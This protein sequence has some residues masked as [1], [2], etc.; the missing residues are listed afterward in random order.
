MSKIAPFGAP[1]AEPTPEWYVMR[2]TYQRELVAQ[3]LL[4]GLGVKSFVPTMKVKRRK[5]GGSFYW[6]E[7][8]K[9]HNYIFVYAT[10]PE[11]QKIK[12][13]KITYLRYMMAKGDEGSPT[14][15]FVPSK[16]MEDFMAVCRSEGVRYLDTEIDL[17]KGDRV[18]ILGGPLKGVEGVYTRTS[19]KHEHRVVVRIEGI[20][21]VATL[22]LPAT[23]VEKVG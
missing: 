3:R 20:A 21:A 14:P 10:L 8:A 16:Q 2:V 1:V 19:L 9:V 11:L 5:V 12:T 7:E 6:R 17:R 4:E 18:R 13:T 22:A 15:Q 23:E